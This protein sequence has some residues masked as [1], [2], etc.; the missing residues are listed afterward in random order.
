MLGHFGARGKQEHGRELCADFLWLFAR[1]QFSLAV[2]PFAV[3]LFCPNVIFTLR[4]PKIR[5]P[6][7]YPIYSKTAK[8]ERCKLFLLEPSIH[9]V[10]HKMYKLQ[11]V[12]LSTPPWG[13]L[14][15]KLS[16]LSCSEA[17]LLRSSSC[18]LVKAA[19]GQAKLRSVSSWL[20]A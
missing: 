13:K 17:K 4:Y 5:Y 11:A 15:M 9:K 8:Q 20:K 3:F 1:V 19:F 18:A 2:L 10:K 7:Y 6:N 12:L 14:V 16:P